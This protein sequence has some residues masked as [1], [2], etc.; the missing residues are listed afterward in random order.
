MEH[1]LKARQVW[2]LEMFNIQGRAERTKSGTLTDASQ[3]WI[4]EMS[5]IHG[6][7]ERTRIW[8]TDCSLLSLDIGNEKIS[9]ERRNELKIRNIDMEHGLTARQVW[10]LEMFDIRGTAERTKVRNMD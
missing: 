7:R 8:N 3:V 2:I 6:T 4:L 10:I 5:N 1:G 9:M